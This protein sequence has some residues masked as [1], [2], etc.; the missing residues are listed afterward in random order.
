MKKI[1]VDFD[2]TIC[3]DK[4]PGIGEMKEGVRETLAVL[5]DLGFY[6]IIWSCRTCRWDYDVYG[7]NPSFP[8]M[9]RGRVQDMVGW[10]AS[11]AIPYDEI[12][13]GSKG[14]PGASYYI[15]DKAIRFE[16][17]WPEI[18]N[19]ILSDEER[20]RKV[21]PFPVSKWKA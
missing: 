2:G 17:N 14:K 9:A 11:H 13:D 6:I 16:N 21:A 15:D 5:R 4:F 18:V 7:G 8:T 19:R 3:E 12:D 1:C 10:L 20:A